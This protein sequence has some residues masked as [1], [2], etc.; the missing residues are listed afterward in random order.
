[1]NSIASYLS[2][3]SHVFP[4]ISNMSGGA[5]ICTCPPDGKRDEKGKICDCES[6]ETNKNTENIYNHLSTHVSTTDSSKN[7]PLQSYD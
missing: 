6:I 5:F 2:I 4:R 7:K 1:M 3:N